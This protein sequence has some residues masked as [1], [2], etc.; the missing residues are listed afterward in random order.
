MSWETQ[1]IKKIWQARENELHSRLK[2]LLGN[3][4]VNSIAW[5]SSILVTFTSFFFYTV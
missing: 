2:L 3:M 1:F 5:G 4:V